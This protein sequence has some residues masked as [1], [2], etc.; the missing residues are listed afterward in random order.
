[1]KR[2]DQVEDSVVVVDASVVIAGLMA[3]GRARRVLLHS[4]VV[5][6]APPLV[7]EEVHDRVDELAKRANLSPGVVSTVLEDLDERIEVAPE[8]L[9]EVHLDEAEPRAADADAEGDEDY[10]A[11][12]L[13]LDAPV[14]TYDDDFDRVEG[15]DVTGTTAVEE[16]LSE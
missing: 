16:G 5:F 9:V 7:L 10:I 13:A 14:W 12:A 15:I 2:L 4:D 6:Y 11:L 3:D 8:G 1:M